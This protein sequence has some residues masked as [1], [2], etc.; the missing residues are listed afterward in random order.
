M[1][2]RVRVVAALCAVALAAVGCSG[3]DRQAVEVEPVT[4]GEVTQTVAA[5]AAV[6]AAAK[7]DVAAAV[8]GVVLA[9]NADDGGRVKRGQT[10]L[11]LAS[12]QV[13]L[14]REQAA[15]AAR[16]AAGVGGVSVDGNGNATLASTQRAVADLD[17]STRPRL[18]QARRR[19][20]R[21][22]DREQRVAAVAAVD[23]VEASYE[24]TRAALLQAGRSLAATQDATAES[25]SRALSQAVA[26]ATSA[27]R[28]QAQAAAAAADRQADNLVVKAPFRGLVQFGK[29]AASDGAPLPADLPP[30]LAG[31]AGSVGALGGGEGG[32]TLRV[33]AP[34]VAGQTLFSVFDVSDIY[35]SADVD[36]VDAPQV[37]IGQRATV[38]VDAFADVPLEG[39][40]ERMAVAATPTTA[41]GVGYPVRIKLLGPVDSADESVL[42]GLRVG[43][44]ASAEIITTTEQSDLVVPSRALL[45][46]D[47]A[48]VVFVVRDGRA[49]QVVVDVAALGEE[50]AAVAGDLTRDDDVVVSGYEELSDGDEVATP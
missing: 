45:R 19:A 24:S 18:R 34:V 26:S 20:Q 13:D 15:A 10:V 44:T 49:V 42:R 43:M 12:T 38:L 4:G 6:E 31:L 41:G 1:S 9:V 48:D 50:R 27:Q 21:I 22:D 28:L 33:G 25:L 39:V 36:E 3:D 29:A 14:A 2:G 23:A 8:S 17:R 46:R 11:R 16:A 40:I 32:G 35:V 5:P 7:Q 47:G 30:E 37:R